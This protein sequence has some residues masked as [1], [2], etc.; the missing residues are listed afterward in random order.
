M[1]LFI[2]EKPSVARVIA[3][4]LGTVKKG[5]G[6]L[7]VG[8][9]FVTWA[10]GHLL[11]MAMPEV[12]DPA[13]AKW[14]AEDLPIVPTTWKMLPKGDDGAKKQLALIGRMLKPA[15]LVINAGD[16]DR[17]GQLLVDE[18]LQAYDYQGP[19]KRFWVSAQDSVSIQRGLADL[20]E[21]QAFHGFADAALARGRAD[22]LIGMNLSRAFTL[23]ARRGGADKTLLTVG[24]VQTPTLAMVVA[25]DRE[26]EAFVPVA[27]ITITAQFQHANGT[28]K[29][30]WK[31][32]QTAE[33]TAAA[34]EPKDGRQDDDAPAKP[35]EG[36]LTDPELAKAILAAVKGKTGVVTTCRTE[37]KQDPPPRP[38]SLGTLTF[39]ASKRWG[40]GAED[41][42][43]A[44]Q[45]LYEAKLVTYPRTDCEYLPESQ[46][47]DAP[48][49]LAAMRSVF[50][51]MA[52]LIERADPTLKSRAW[53][54][55]K[56]TA[57]HG[58]IPT[59]HRGEVARLSEI[60]AN[61]YQLVARTY[62]AQFYPAHRYLAT[63]VVVEVEGH[64]F[65][66]NGRVVVDPGWQAIL[67]P[68]EPEKD[69]D[70]DDA[71]QTL[72]EMRETDPVTCLKADKKEKKTKPPPRFTEGTLVKAM[73]T[74]H[75]FIEDPELKKLLKEEDGIGTP[76]TRASIISELKRR[77]FLEARKKA[78]ASTELGRSLV[79]AL[80]PDVKSPV[81]TALYERDFKE[82]QAGRATIE[83]FLAKQTEFVTTQVRE[84]NGR[85]TTI[86]G[87]ASDGPECPVC[88]IGRLRRV[89]GKQGHFWSCSRWRADDPCK[90][91]WEDDDGK[92]AF[93][94]PKGSVPCP[95]CK[96]GYLRRIG[97]KD[98]FFWGCSRFREG[99]KG[100]AEDQDGKP[101]LTPGAA[102]GVVARSV[103]DREPTAG[104]SARE[105][106][107][108]PRGPSGTPPAAREPSAARGATGVRPAW[109]SKAATAGAPPMEPSS[110]RRPSSLRAQPEPEDGAEPLTLL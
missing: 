75:K 88:K 22:W 82:I 43:K 64:T 63:S 42:L 24:R 31:P 18:I 57:H 50:P 72:P 46:H 13:F 33:A 107:A 37:E 106:L 48:A 66:T 34:D 28:F 67:K 99:C 109:T 40:Y 54:D 1:R 3:A 69:K 97:Y 19:V 74:V 5:D 25:R 98:K 47:T 104:F 84:A 86:A 61:L 101:V 17:E 65:A 87:A 45:N 96:S 85:S 108:T 58:M 110:T 41:V 39:A 56:I 27:Y 14:R 70:D 9:D 68:D 12:Y 83:A 76:A 103:P 53:N 30:R 71:A 11:E 62:L 10:F 23:S 90:A 79:D 102:P 80:P 93:A 38:F 29:A 2:A 77:R 4:E 95:V 105:I 51:A 44:A 7:Q 52:K 81:L 91:T 59:Q 49:V 78:L 6:W 32:P 26:I 92:P 94:G 89:P 55:E 100:S 35:V 21:N 20:K 16:P 36:R 60:E 73:E 8:P 15:T